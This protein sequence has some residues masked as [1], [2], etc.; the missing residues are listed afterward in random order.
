MKRVILL[1]L[2]VPTLVVGQGRVHYA[3]V[4][5]GAANAQVAL[6]VS[7]L[8]LWKLGA[9]KKLAL[10]LGGRLT[11]YFGN[12]QYYTTAPAELTSGGTGP[13][14]IFKDDILANIDSFLVRSPQANCL[15]ISLNLEYP[16][17]KNIT[18]GFNI[19]MIGFSFGSSRSGTYINGTTSTPVNASPTPFNIL[20]VS[21]NDRGSLNSEMYLRYFFNE[22]IAIKLG[23]QF[24]FTEYTTT[25]NVQTY[26]SGND[27]FRNKSLM[28]CLGV[29]KTL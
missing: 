5:L 25:Y 21:D 20:L 29:S 9:N 14:V 12:N 13:G 6:S 7:Y 26:P 1:L 8:H 23:A 27:R 28:V 22:R 15:N 3:D 18:A 2:F 16:L 10:G 17:S 19:D 24:L 4:T 11:S